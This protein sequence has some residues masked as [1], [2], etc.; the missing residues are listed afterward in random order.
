MHSQA[1]PQMTNC[2]PHFQRLHRHVTPGKPG[3][4]SGSDMCY[5]TPATLA[6]LLRRGCVL[7]LLLRSLPL[8]R[9]GVWHFSREKTC[10][11]NGLQ[12]LAKS[13]YFGVGFTP[14]C[15]GSIFGGADY[16]RRFVHAVGL[17]CNPRFF[18]CRGQYAVDA[19]T[20]PPKGVTVVTLEKTV[21]GGSSL[22]IFD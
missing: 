9:F 5:S 12:A 13:R 6:G 20:L 21:T 17:D 10:Q 8:P 11:A 14:H 22:P 7:G 1:A 19:E 2:Q 18:D 3:C 15:Q 16:G 4:Q